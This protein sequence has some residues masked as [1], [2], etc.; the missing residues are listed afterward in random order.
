[1]EDLF[2][3]V[4]VALNEKAHYIV[5]KVCNTYAMYAL[6]IRLLGQLAE[7]FQ[8]NRKIVQW[9]LLIDSCAF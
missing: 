9:S 7:Q 8:L 5:Y 1:M 3:A 2:F 4:F 6:Y